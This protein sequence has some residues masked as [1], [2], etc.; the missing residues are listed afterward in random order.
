MIGLLV[1]GFTADWFVRKKG[2]RFGRRFTGM[3]G[4]GMCCIFI[5]FTAIIPQNNIAIITLVAANAFYGFGVMS[6][7]A[8]CSDIARNNS[9]TVTGA[10]NFFGQTGAFFLAIVFGKIADA[11]LNFN[12]PLFAV[13]FVLFIGFLLWVAIDPLRQLKIPAK[14]NIKA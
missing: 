12:Y 9:G 10:M 4:I 5:L 7:Y 14:Y 8:V 11:T 1:S 2:V 13:A 3:T 6:A